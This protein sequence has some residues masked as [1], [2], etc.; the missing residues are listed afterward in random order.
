MRLPLPGLYNVYN[1]LGAAALCLEL[2]VGLDTV[3]AGLE[4]VTAAFGRAETVHA[5]SAELSILLIK[6]PAGANEIL[7]TLALEPGPLELLA[8]LNDRTADGR[9]VSWVWDADFELLADLVGRVTCAGTRAAEL[10]LRF[11]YAGV[12]EDRLNVV[13][14]LAP[15][16]D[17][18]ISG[19]GGRPAVRSTHL[20]GAARA[21]R[22]ARLARTRGT[23]LAG[24]PVSVIWHDIECGAYC[25]DL[26]VWRALAREHPG[27]ILDIGAGTGRVA[28]DLAE[29]GHQVVALDLD[30]ALLA[31]LSRPGGRAARRDR[32]RRR[33]NFKLEATFALIVVPMQTI[34][35]LGGAAGRAPFFERVWRHLA[36]DGVVAIA[37]GDQLELY[38]V[39]TTVGGPLPDI[40]ELEGVLYSSQ[41]TAVRE[42]PARV[43]ARAPPRD[44]RP[45][46]APDR[47]AG[48]D[49]DRR[50]EARTSSSSRAS[51][52]A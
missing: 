38:E 7:R 17:S 5:G 14:P 6:N 19:G 3:V 47:R 22:G 9:D 50:V 8:I 43:R 2:G 36:A 15:A 42:D 25:A 32:R 37:I 26:P 4:H 1:A 31:E 51:R 33:Q 46:R 21:P 27:P 16:L 35:L 20:H 29:R 23:V 49:P 45:R 18:A 24:R 41:P 40:R 10:A 13:G 48:R 39:E 12:P 52:P 44:G 11:K 34:Q 30:G 28:L